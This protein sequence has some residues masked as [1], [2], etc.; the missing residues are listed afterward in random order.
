MFEVMNTYFLLGVDV[1]C[2]GFVLPRA[3]ERYLNQPEALIS[4]E[5]NVTDQVQICGCTATP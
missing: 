4:V 5:Q 1:R 2:S 3:C